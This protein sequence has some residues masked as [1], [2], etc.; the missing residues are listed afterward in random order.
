M[1]PMIRQLKQSAEY[2]ENMPKPLIVAVNAAL[3]LFIGFVDYVTGYEL[4]ISLLYLIPVGFAVWYGS[5]SLG[6]IISCLS[7]LTIATADFMAGK[8]TSH[9]FIEIWNLLMHLGFFMVY[10]FV[11][12]LVKSDLDERA[13]L[14]DELRKTLAEVKQLRGFLP[15]CASCKKIR[16]DK[17]YWNQLETYISA[18]SEVQF[19]HGI[20]PDCVKKLYPE[21]YERIL[22]IK[23]LGR[24]E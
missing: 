13:L 12:S 16:D 7:V 6:M 24:R 10:A 8:Q 22:G 15:I 14:I 20:C 21:E 11:L 17:G 3:L 4:G 5:R 9:L 2:F 18:H 23:D 19:S 1:T